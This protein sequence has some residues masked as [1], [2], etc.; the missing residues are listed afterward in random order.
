[1]SG[2]DLASS[3]RAACEHGFVKTQE[4]E[5]ARQLRRELGLPVK[6]IARRVGV[7]VG[8]VSLWIR[9]VPW[10]LE[11]IAALDARN[12]VRSGQRSG[13]T[14]NSRRRRQERRAAQEHGRV[15]ARMCEPQFIAGCMLYWA[16]GAKN[17]NNV[18]LAN[19][20]ADLPHAFLRFL[21]AY[22]GVPDDKIAFS[23]NCFLRNGFTLPQIEQWW[24]ERLALPP[25]SL[26]KAAVNRVSS[27]SQRKRG[28][29]LPTAR[30]G[31]RCITRSSRRASTARSRSTPG[32]TGRSG[33]ICR[34]W[35]VWDSN[36]EP[37]D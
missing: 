21:R 36:P 22:F 4:R 31:S 7:S 2:F 35:A 1:M 25:C 9:D 12:P 28:H 19:S 6:E 16:E 15:L 18:V 10:S 8:S 17:R 11:Q 24:L 23:V 3:V 37:R 14:N 26:R 5:L 20:D 29:V 30:D 34:K 13:T 27:A 32:S 33:W